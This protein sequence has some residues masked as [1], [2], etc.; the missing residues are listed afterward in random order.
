MQ[1]TSASSA[2]LLVCLLLLGTATLL[3]LSVPARCDVFT[4]W[5]NVSAPS[6]PLSTYS[7]SA[8]DGSL[9]RLAA[10]CNLSA[11]LDAARS[12]AVTW[13]VAE[14]VS[15]A[16]LLTLDALSASCDPASL[17]SDDVLAALFGA[18]ILLIGD[19][20]TRYQYLSLV[21][22]LETGR[23]QSSNFYD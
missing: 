21:F 18:H 19:S 16:S 8:L 15:G 13:R 2:S 10:A 1:Q 4:P 3:A 7:S 20:L 17:P 9:R 12:G 5:C 6:P 22:F 14:P 23:W 11:L